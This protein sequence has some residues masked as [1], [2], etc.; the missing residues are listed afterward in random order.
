MR[1][2][3]IAGLMAAGMLAG[4]GG[5][6]TDG[7]GE[8][9]IACADGTA[10]TGSA[11]ECAKKCGQSDEGKKHAEWFSMICC[12]GSECRTPGAPSICIDYCNK[13]GDGGYC[14]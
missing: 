12:D 4:C 5:T 7:N 3:I 6:T 14:G 1:R 8:V 11:D 10:C 13:Y 9:H 2:T